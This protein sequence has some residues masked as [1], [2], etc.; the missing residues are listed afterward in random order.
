MMRILQIAIGALIVMMGVMML[1][2]LLRSDAHDPTGQN[3]MAPLSLVGVGAFAISS[4]R[5]RKR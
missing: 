5:K 2:I 3:F 4:A 1:F